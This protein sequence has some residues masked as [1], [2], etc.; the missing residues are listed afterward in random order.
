[1]EVTVWVIFLELN[2]RRTEEPGLMT[3]A[4]VEVE[5]HGSS[6]IVSVESE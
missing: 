3:G 5:F 6:E 4:P 2:F 1:M